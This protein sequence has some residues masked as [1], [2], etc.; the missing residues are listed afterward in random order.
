MRTIYFA[1][2][3]AGQEIG[4]LIERRDEIEDKLK[5]RGFKVLNPLRDKFIYNRTNEKDLIEKVY[6]D[7]FTCNEIVHRDILFVKQSDIILIDFLNPSIGS[8]CELTL[9]HIF[10]KM[11]I[12]V[13]NNEK[14]Y[15]HP[16]V[17]SFASKIFNDMDKAI[18]YIINFCY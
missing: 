12:V 18:E 16:W 13:S 3:F 2:T 10:D 1:G 6:E 7:N 9:G 14:V 5:F 8:S 4:K 11:I 15:K 17:H